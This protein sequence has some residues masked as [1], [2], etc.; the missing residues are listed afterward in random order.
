[1]AKGYEIKVMPAKDA[2]VAKDVYGVQEAEFEC[3]IVEVRR[4]TSYTPDRLH[5][6]A[7]ASSDDQTK[8]TE[9]IQSPSAV[10]PLDFLGHAEV[11]PDLPLAGQAQ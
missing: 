3:G 6:F 9:A 5:T 4:P 11:R 1:M 10:R 8:K 2:T 7:G